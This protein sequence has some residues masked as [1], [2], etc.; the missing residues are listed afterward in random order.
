MSTSLEN[1]IE[2]LKKRL[3]KAKEQKKAR[4]SLIAAKAKKQSRKDETRKKIL[5][6][7][8]VMM[9]A[10]NNP[11]FKTTLQMLLDVHITSAADRAFL[12]LHALTEKPKNSTQTE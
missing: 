9:E 1:E 4:D 7:A 6:G 11:E 3:E 8:V 2:N 10:K 5:T 12:S